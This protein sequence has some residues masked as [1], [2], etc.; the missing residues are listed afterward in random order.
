MSPMSPI[1]PLGRIVLGYTGY[2]VQEDG[3]IV[4]YFRWR[5]LFVRAWV[6]SD[7]PGQRTRSHYD[8]DN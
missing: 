6:S 5:R 8:L 3:V 1:V 4:L 2:R 7:P